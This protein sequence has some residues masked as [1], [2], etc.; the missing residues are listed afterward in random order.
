MYIAEVKVISWFEYVTFYILNKK[1]YR[2][3][4]PWVNRTFFPFCDSEA[5][6]NK[7]AAI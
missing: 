3:Q 6:R 2:R 4:N 1:C 5:D 7:E